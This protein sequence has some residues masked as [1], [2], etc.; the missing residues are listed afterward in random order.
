MPTKN[1]PAN[2]RQA[3]KSTRQPRD[4]G[5][6]ANRETVSVTQR[7][8][9]V[10]SMG[11]G[12]VSADRFMVWI[13]PA[14]GLLSL[15]PLHH[16]AVDDG[17]PLAPGRLLHHPLDAR[18]KGIRDARQ[19]RLRLGGPTNLPRVSLLRRRQIKT[20]RDEQDVGRGRQEDRFGAAAQGGNFVMMN[21]RS[22][23]HDHSGVDGGGPGRGASAGG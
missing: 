9:I 19:H 10:G 11:K 2:A 14:T 18:A 20:P 3:A 6:S 17:N 1:Q 12:A 7:E 22:S 13:I 4:A 23:H 21:T 5:R 15:K 8:S 16:S